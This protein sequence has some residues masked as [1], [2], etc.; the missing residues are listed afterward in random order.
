MKTTKRILTGTS[1]FI[2]GIVFTMT[3][4]VSNRHHDLD[5]H[6]GIRKSAVIEV[7]APLTVSQM[8][9]LGLI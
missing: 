2:L 8:K 5:S 4:A 1:L 3:V 7:G 9:N 6:A